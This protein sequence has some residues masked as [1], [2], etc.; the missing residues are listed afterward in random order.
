[1]GKVSSWSFLSSK[2]DDLLEVP[3]SKRSGVRP[4]LAVGHGVIVRS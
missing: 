3:A 2:H 4:S 1:M